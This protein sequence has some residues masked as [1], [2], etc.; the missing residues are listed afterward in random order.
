MVLVF[1]VLS[2]L[3]LEIACASSHVL[4]ETDT[5]DYVIIGGGTSGLVVAN[6]LSEDAS[7]TVLVVEHGYIDNNPYT[8]IP[9]AV[10]QFPD[11]AEL[12][13][14][15]SAPEPYLGGSTFPVRMAS[16][17]GGG[18]VVNGMLADRGSKADYDAWEALGNEGWG[19][20]GLFPY[21]RKSTNFTPPSPGLAEDFDIQW[22]P[23]AYGQGPL[24]IGFPSMFYPDLRNMTSTWNARGVPMPARPASG[25]AIGFLWAPSTL[26]TRSGTRCHARVAYYDPVADRANLH[27]IT[28]E[29]VVEIIFDSPGLT[30]IGVEMISRDDGTVR[31]A[32]AS[33]E[34]VLAA[35]AIS[36]PKLLQL[37]GIGPANAL[38]EAGVKVKKE[39]AAVGANFQD[40]PVVSTLWNSSNLAFPNPESIYTNATYNE[41]AWEEY[42]TRHTGP[43]TN[44]G[45]NHVVFLPLSELTSSYTAILNKIRNQ[46]VAEY[47]PSI[48]EDNPELLK[49]FEAQRKILI[50]HFS[51]KDAAPA[52]IFVRIAAT[53]AG[54]IQKPL[55]R[56]T[57]TLDPA[58]PRSQPVV[59]FNTLM[60]PVDRDV[61]LSMVRYIR[62]FNQD[63]LLAGY[64][65]VETVPGESAQTDEEI[66]EALLAI[67]G[68]RPTLA[69]PSC[70]CAMMPEEIG[71][72]VS[73]DLLVYG[74]DRLSVVD[75]S[76]MPLIPAT[77]LQTTVY[78]V[79][80]KASDII[81]ARHIYA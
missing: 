76:I 54:S 32:Y 7:V 34:V 30:A 60:N 4:D 61:L 69:H 25:D 39:L 16:V 20:D 48:Y 65:P 55:S 46:T 2:S 77:H 45:G 80:E 18:S 78:A 28:G 51:R 52:E 42:V 62:E 50:D 70:T 27:L 74:T 56:G 24:Q 9:Q 58:D 67:N 40:H 22:D 43:Y 19:W 49:G 72:C 59:H 3:I 73:S 81:K 66:M 35:G 53:S 12:W 37:S 79:A 21:F 33:K 64:V 41:S 11:T 36:T 75:A 71:G 47:L 6:R 23:E 5:F 26:D 1:A 31:K 29:E 57:V 68:I 38:K 8:Q 15:T 14:V 44:P 13:N 10:A 63:P 17:V